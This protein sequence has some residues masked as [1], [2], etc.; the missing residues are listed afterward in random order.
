MPHSR[1]SNS[2][3]TSRLNPIICASSMCDVHN[4]GQTLPFAIP[5]YYG[6][7]QS[8]DISAVSG[9]FVSSTI[10]SN[11]GLVIACR[12]RIGIFARCVGRTERPD[13]LHLFPML[14]NPTGCKTNNRSHAPDLASRA[15]LNAGP[16][17]NPRICSEKSGNMQCPFLAVSLHSLFRTSM[18]FPH[19]QSLL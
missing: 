14:P 4:P 12:T 8:I 19:S 9:L 11:S 7:R 10:P 15:P 5:I 3:K 18:P 1:H 17:P 16:S 2:L 6:G 13:R